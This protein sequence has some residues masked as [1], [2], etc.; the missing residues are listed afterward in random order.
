MARPVGGILLSQT[1]KNSPRTVLMVILAFKGVMSVIY[2]S[3]WSGMNEMG[4][5]S[6]LIALFMRVQAVLDCS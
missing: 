2:S 1:V 3:K 6:E 5:S 4:L